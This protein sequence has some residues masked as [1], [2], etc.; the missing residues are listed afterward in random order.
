MLHAISWKIVKDG[1]FLY[2]CNEYFGVQAEYTGTQKQWM[3]WLFPL[4]DEHQ[5]T[6]SYFARDTNAAKTLFL[7]MLKMDGVGPKTAYAISLLDRVLLEKAIEL[8]DVN[9]FQ[10]IPGIGPKTAKRLVIELK[11]VVKE[12]DFAKISGDDKVVKDI[13]KY[14][15]G[16][17]Y[18]AD[19]VKSLLSSYDGVIKKETTGE[20]V[21]WLFSKM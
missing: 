14:C 9:F 2:I 10:K 5:K 15:K 11:T 13:I 7:K 21:K 18:D 16:L 20:V 12:N 17:G 6:M 1:D 19:A 4:M 8:T 3:F